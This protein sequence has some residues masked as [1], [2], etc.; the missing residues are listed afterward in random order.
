M[1][2]GTSPHYW[3]P[4]DDGTPDDSD[5]TD[6]IDSP[7]YTLY[8]TAHRSYVSQGLPF[9][10]QSP[11]AILDRF[12]G[13]PDERNAPHW[14]RWATPTACFIHRMASFVKIFRELASC[15]VN[16]DQVSPAYPF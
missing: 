14:T 1:R 9:L 12:V 11:W 5:R 3:Q 15:K 13:H 16:S 6:I 4:P 2:N 7:T 10:S 8:I